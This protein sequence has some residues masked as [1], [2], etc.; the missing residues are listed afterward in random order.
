MKKLVSYTYPTGTNY[1]CK[2]CGFEAMLDNPDLEE[3]PECGSTDI[4]RFV[5]DDEVVVEELPVRSTTRSKIGTKYQHLDCYAYVL[6]YETRNR[7]MY[8]ARNGYVDFDSPSMQIFDSE[9]TAKQSA[10]HRRTYGLI[11]KKVKIFND[12]IS[13][14]GEKR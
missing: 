1:Y 3:C 10:K 9:I 13:L 11:P 5:N 6:Q 8:S 14:V 7:I 4:E 2:H 12:N